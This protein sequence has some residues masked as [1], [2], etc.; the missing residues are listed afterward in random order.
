MQWLK[1][2]NANS[3]LN[4]QRYV[5]KCPRSFVV[6][7]NQKAIV[8]KAM[9]TRENNSAVQPVLTLEDQLEALVTKK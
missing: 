4:P 5:P 1:R 2:A 9:S 6:E 3:A 7:M 8:K